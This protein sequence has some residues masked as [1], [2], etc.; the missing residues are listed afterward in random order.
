MSGVLLTARLL[1]AAVFLVAAMAKLA[2]R[3]GSRRAVRQFGVPDALSSLIGALLP[4]AELT[5]AG[6][7]I[8]H[9]TAPPE[10][11]TL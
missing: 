5:A 4:L 7:L 9:P 6:A 11:F 8:A 3:E 10:R 1:L 2:D